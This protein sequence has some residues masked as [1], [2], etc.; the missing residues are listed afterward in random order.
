MQYEKTVNPVLLVYDVLRA[1]S[2]AR[3]P[4]R[5]FRLSE[6]WLKNIYRDENNQISVSTA[7]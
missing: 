7:M 2:G 6:E 4:F 3:F 5:A 1:E